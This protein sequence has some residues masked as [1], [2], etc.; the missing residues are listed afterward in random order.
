M[1][2][3][4]PAPLDLEQAI[5]LIERTLQDCERA[6]SPGDLTIALVRANLE[7]TRYM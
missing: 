1:T 4:L 5:P 2:A 3:F 7:Q 6:L